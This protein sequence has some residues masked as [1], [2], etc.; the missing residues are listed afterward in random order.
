MPRVNIFIR[1]ANEEKWN[2]IPDKSNWVNTILENSDDTT[3]YGLEKK[4]PARPMVTVM[5]GAIEF[6]KHNA[7]KGLCKRGC[8]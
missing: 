3:Q 2:N 7:V 4:T 1:K 5:S 8:K 6:C